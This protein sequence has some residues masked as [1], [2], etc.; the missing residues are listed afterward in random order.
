MTVGAFAVLHYLSTADR[1]VETVDDLAGVGRTHPGAA[2]LMCC[3]C[4]A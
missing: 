1:P 2:L 4:S 3:S